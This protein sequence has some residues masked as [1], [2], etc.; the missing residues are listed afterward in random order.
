MK[1]KE[2]L[3]LKAFINEHFDFYGL[4]EIGLFGKDIKKSDYQKQADRIC[5]FFGFKSIFE[6]LTQEPIRAHIDFIPSMF[7]CPICTCEQR[8]PDSNLGYFTFKCIGCKRK[9]LAT[10]S[11]FKGVTIQEVG[12]YKEKTQT[13]L[14]EDEKSFIYKPSR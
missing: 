8:M 4:R 14:T 5:Q 1:T 9:L 13:E 7:K 3:A 6:W 11:N 2:D 12:G 10:G